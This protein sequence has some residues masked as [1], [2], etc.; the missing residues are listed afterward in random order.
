M[1]DSLFTAGSV[2]SVAAGEAP[3][4]RATASTDKA[5][6]ASL[7][8]TRAVARQTVE[9]EGRYQV[10]I[11]AETMRVITE[12]VDVMTGDV[13]LYL[14]PGYRPDAQKQAASGSETKP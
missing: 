3:R 14:P 10:R 2:A 6:A 8:E 7:P 9:R 4:Q 13:L 12:I 5:R 11:H 1:S